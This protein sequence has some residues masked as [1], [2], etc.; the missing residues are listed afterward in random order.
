[1][2]CSNQD[3]Q[4]GELLELVAEKGLNGI[5]E[6]VT[7]LLNLAM[8]LEREQ[9]LQAGSYE[10]TEQRN[11]YANGFKPKTV[12]TRMGKIELAVP[13]VRDS[14]FYPNSLEKGL[15]S[16]R[17]LK[18]SLA[19]MYIQGVSTRKVA[20]ITEKMCGFN[21]SSS[22]VSK[23][24]AELDDLLG[25]WRNRP[26]ASYPYVYLDAT[27]QKVRQGGQV[28]D[29]ATLIAVG[30][31]EEGKREI[32]GVSVNLSE[33]EV[34]WR[35]FLQSLQ[36]RG[37][38][39]AR[40]FISD[41]HAGLNAARKGVFP[42]IPW[43]RCQFHLQ[44]N[45]QSYIPKKSLKKP[46]AADIRAIFN[47]PNDAEAKRFLELFVKKYAVQAPKLSEWAETNIP[48]GLAVMQFPLEHQLRIRTSNMLERVNKEVKRRTKVVGLFPNEDSCL[49]L[50]SAVL[51]EI[52][53]DWETKKAYL[54][55]KQ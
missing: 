52:S 15:R 9:H 5:S 25:Q 2:T 33:H 13:Q 23:A 4:F 30:I 10:R 42:S 48:E 17:A 44:Q 1:M 20:R 3:T 38:H 53:D 14:S 6:P 19:E 34:H 28:V 49:R 31:D 35:S 24:S 54:N 45:A 40:L 21:I 47:A 46:V 27:Y 32:L 37:L 8:R 7:L 29:C 26:L 18:L 55:F 22:Q 41:A 51:M 50:I 12:K 16:E 36:K 39:G 43:Q 11:G